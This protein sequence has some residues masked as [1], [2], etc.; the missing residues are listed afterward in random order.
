MFSIIALNFLKIEE[1]FIKQ[2]FA[3]NHYGILLI[4]L[5]V[6]LVTVVNCPKR[7]QDKGRAT[8]SKVKWAANSRKIVIA[9]KLWT[10]RLGWPKKAGKTVT[11]S[12][13]QLTP[14]CFF[15]GRVPSDLSLWAI[16]FRSKSNQINQPFI[17]TD[18]GQG[19]IHK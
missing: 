12:I 19:V 4:S 5:V 3:I 6:D 17:N 15:F 7:W 10:S 16:R 14:P 18:N 1:V 8:K 11:C 2:N 9:Q 13:Q